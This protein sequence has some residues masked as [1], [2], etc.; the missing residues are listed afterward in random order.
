MLQSYRW[1][2][3][4]L[5]S[6]VFGLYCLAGD[7]PSTA[8]I[9]QDIDKL[10]GN[11][12]CTKMVGDGQEAPAE[13]VSKVIFTFKGDQVANSIDPGDLATIKI[14]PSK[15]PTTIDFIDKDNKVDEGIYI[16]E[17]DTL[18]FCMSPSESKKPRPTSFESTK[19]NSTILAVFTRKK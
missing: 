7:N 3:G 2:I 5:V 4:V 13:I 8:Q 9:K 11:W 1:S 17:G 10:Q 14:D 19:E 18:K 15:T 6:V 12:Q 16:I